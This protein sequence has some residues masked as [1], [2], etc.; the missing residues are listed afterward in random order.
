[1]AN[2]SYRLPGGT[3]AQAQEPDA[4]KG[5][6]KLA[7]NREETAQMLSICVK[8]LDRL[9]SSR[10]IPS[11]KVCRRRI[12]ALEDILAWLEK[13]VSSQARTS[14]MAATVVSFPTTVNRKEAA[15]LLSLGVR[16]F[17]RLVISGEIPKI[18]ITRKLIFRTQDLVNWVRSQSTK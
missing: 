5:T 7:L 16:L 6:K 1:M 14:P 17:D 2:S 4:T 3:I 8:T 11:I 18:R 13:N 10:V 15:R 9:A 12:F